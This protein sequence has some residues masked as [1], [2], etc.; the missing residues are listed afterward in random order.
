M[1]PAAGI[2]QHFARASLEAVGYVGWQTWEQLRSTQLTDVPR[3]P[4][5][6]VVYR[7]DTDIPAFL[8][9]NPGGRFKGKDPTIPLE[10]MAAGRVPG[11]NVVYVGKADDL[12]TRLKA[13]ARFGAGDPVAHWGG[14]LIWQLADSDELLV[15]WCPIT[16][17]QPARDHEKILPARFAERHGGRR[18]LANLTG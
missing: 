8:P 6:Y 9:A 18:P 13:Y 4:G 12:R 15:A 17:T 2:P 11:A 3:T 5:C 1:S 14:R 7:R 10:R 16:T